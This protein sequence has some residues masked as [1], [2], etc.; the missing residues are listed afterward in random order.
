MFT[1]S[2]V[3]QG[4]IKFSVMT[5]AIANAQP[6]KK[7]REMVVELNP[8][9]L[10]LILGEKEADVQS[11]IEFLCQ[12][13]EKSRTEAKGG[14]RLIQRGEYDYLLVNGIKYRNIRNQEQRRDDN[15]INQALHRWRKKRLPEAG[16]L[17]YLKALREGDDDGAERILEKYQSKKAK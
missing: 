11:A 17:E 12:P 4:A 8:K 9:L 2:M 3:G 10:G 5:Y 14:R 1:G 7:A 16:E 15:R 13:D 6:D